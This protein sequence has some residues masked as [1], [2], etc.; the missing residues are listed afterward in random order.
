MSA[1]TTT[2]V[3]RVSGH[4]RSLAAY[5]TALL[6]AV[7]AV[8]STVG[9]ETISDHSSGAGRLSEALVGIAFLTA[10]V[11]L[12]LF[13]PRGVPARVTSL[14]GIA[15]TALTG[16]AMLSVTVTGEEWPEPIVTVLV[17]V[18]LVGLVAQGVIG[19]RTRVWPWWA[20]LLV[21]L[22]L[23]AMFFLPNPVN[24][25]VMALIWAGVGLAGR[26]S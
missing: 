26:R 6:I 25:V 17:L 2:A 12:V 11:A 22:F 8:V 21:S 3:D 23:P 14:P 20:G 19:W 16:V 15:A 13:L 4:G 18:N 1:T 5:G 10:A 7:D 24:S 9:S